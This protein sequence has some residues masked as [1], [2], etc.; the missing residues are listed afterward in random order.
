MDYHLDPIDMLA[1]RLAQL[2]V[3]AGAERVTIQVHQVGAAAGLRGDCVAQA[4]S[5]YLGLG[6]Y[7]LTKQFAFGGAIILTWLRCFRRVNTR[8]GVHAVPPVKLPLC[9]KAGELIFF[10]LSLSQV[11]PR[12]RW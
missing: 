7:C 1:G 9:A 12:H 2:E 4:V 11:Y 5:P 3:E 10:E 6:C 8:L